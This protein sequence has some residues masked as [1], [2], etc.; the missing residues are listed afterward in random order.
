MAAQ[1]KRPS[2]SI[3]NKS[4]AYNVVDTIQQIKD[5]ASDVTD[6]HEARSKLPPVG[7]RTQGPSEARWT[8]FNCT[9]LITIARGRRGKSS[10][11]CE[12][13]GAT[14]SVLP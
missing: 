12:T 7:D 2:S 3:V 6:Y 4:P 13:P 1:N 8:T 14:F 10:P 11:S 5:P 9:M